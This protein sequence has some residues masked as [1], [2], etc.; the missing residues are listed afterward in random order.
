MG[1]L[2]VDETIQARGGFILGALVY[3]EDDPTE[4]VHRALAE[5]GYT[6][7]VNEFH[8]S[9]R[10]VGNTQLQ[11]LRDRVHGALEGTS[12]AVVVAADFERPR[13]GN[14]VLDGIRKVVAANQLGSPHDIY[15]DEGIR[16]ENRGIVVPAFCA[17]LGVHL[18]T[19]Q[20]SRLIAGL[21]LADLVAHTAGIMLL[22]SLGLVNKVIKVG[23]ESGYPADSD[24]EL[25]FAL[26]ASLRYRF[27][28]GESLYP[29][30]DD[31]VRMATIKTEDTA[32]HIASCTPP[33]L[34][35]AAVSRFGAMYLGCIQWPA[36]NWL[37][38]T[39][40]C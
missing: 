37:Q 1:H 24:M 9:A 14:H 3:S 29:G 5:A 19:E 20:D 17:S 8:S 39:V 2:F 32:L 12:I 33:P 21:Q 30:D 40:R 26:W 16:I 25:G 13:F 36:N 23:E 11:E 10:F 6:P 38:R 18:H 27:F 4:E 22:D 7:G 34:Q 31:F 15:L 35:E 28:L